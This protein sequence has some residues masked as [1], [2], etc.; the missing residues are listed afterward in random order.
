[1]ADDPSKPRE[2]S[3]LLKKLR[4][5]RAELQAEHERQTRAEVRGAQDALIDAAVEWVQDK[6]GDGTQVRTA[7]A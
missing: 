6:W 7:A 5:R 1:M 3:Q 4:A 2:Q